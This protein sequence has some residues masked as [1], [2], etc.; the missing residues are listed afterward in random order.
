MG[1]TD[2]VDSKPR[3]AKL[4]AGAEPAFDEALTASPQPR[5]PAGMCLILYA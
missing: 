4:A 5:I 2:T 3:I 1:T